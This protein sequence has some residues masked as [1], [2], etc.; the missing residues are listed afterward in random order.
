[1]YPLILFQVSSFI[2]VM[3]ISRSDLISYSALFLGVF[4]AF[5]GM[6]YMLFGTYSAY[7]ST[8]TSTLEELMST[9]LG[10]MHFRDLEKL[11]S[12]FT[13]AYF[14]LYIIVSISVLTNT[15]IAIICDAI[16]KVSVFLKI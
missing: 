1:M 7:Y 13:K 15:L 5:G 9:M 14:I 3:A 6:G 12:E 16:S 11:S 8:I 4:L 10:K 2:N